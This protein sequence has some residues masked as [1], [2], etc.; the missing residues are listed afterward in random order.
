L[1]EAVEAKAGASA[2]RRI[3]AAT[4]SGPASAFFAAVSEKVNEV[5]DAA[6][7]K[8]PLERSGVSSVAKVERLTLE[9]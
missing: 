8:V 9:T 2:L 3:A 7:R 6:S 4:A 5:G 1:A